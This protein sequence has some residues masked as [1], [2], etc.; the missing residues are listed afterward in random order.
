MPKKKEVKKKYLIEVDEDQLFALEK[1]CDTLARILCGQDSTMQ[2]ILEKAWHKNVQEPQN[3]EYTC[4][5]FWDMR[6]EVEET[7]MRLKALCF[8]LPRNGNYGINYSEESDIL[9]DMYHT[10]RYARYNSMSDEDKE[11][12]RWS[13]MADSPMHCSKTCPLPIVTQI[14]KKKTKK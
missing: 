2:D 5:E 13:V 7:L 1:G 9:I 14:D 4:N 3:L 12:C 8:N 10:F 11:K 6:H